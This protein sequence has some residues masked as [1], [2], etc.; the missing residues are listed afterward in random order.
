MGFEVI[1]AQIIVAFAPADAIAKLF[2]SFLMILTIERVA[3]LYINLF[4]HAKAKLA[5][6]Q[7]DP[8]LVNNL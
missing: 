4:L 6:A 5:P 2:P 7:F 8:E 3:C 1:V